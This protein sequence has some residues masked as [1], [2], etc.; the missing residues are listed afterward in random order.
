MSK[1]SNFTDEEIEHNRRYLVRFDKKNA[2]RSDSLSDSDNE[3][4]VN[5][6]PS[7]E[8]EQHFSDEYEPA[9]NPDEEW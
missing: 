4:D 5:K 3:T 8:E 9:K 6:Y 1:C 2:R 7:E